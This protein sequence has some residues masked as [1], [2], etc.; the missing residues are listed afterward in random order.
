M[1]AEHIY[2]E[3]T[4]YFYQYHFQIYC[5]F[6][7]VLVLHFISLRFLSNAQSNEGNLTSTADPNRLIG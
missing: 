2:V 3:G 7:F 1:G 5:R 4:H 6:L